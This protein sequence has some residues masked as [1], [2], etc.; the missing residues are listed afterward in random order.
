MVT[1]TDAKLL[2]APVSVFR[3]VLFASRYWIVHA[4][5]ACLVVNALYLF[6]ETS[7]PIGKHDFIGMTFRSLTKPDESD[8]AIVKYC[9]SLVAMI[10]SPFPRWVRD[11]GTA[12]C[13]FGSH[14]LSVLLFGSIVDMQVAAF[15]IVWNG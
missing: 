10:P 12:C 2:E 14:D 6:H 13:T 7:M 1:R 9:K 15:C 3:R 4:T 5:V 11:E 8:L